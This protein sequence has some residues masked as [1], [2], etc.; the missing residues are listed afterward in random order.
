[1]YDASS[2]ARNTAA[3]ATSHA[4]PMRPVGDAAWRARVI[5]STS[6]YAPAIWP[7]TIG[8]SISPGQIA[9][10]RIPSRAY[11]SARPTVS[12]LTAP[13]AA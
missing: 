12:W 9:L 2:L 6:S 3:L 4:V 8:V 11:R 10:T 7:R 5:A 13:L 1:M